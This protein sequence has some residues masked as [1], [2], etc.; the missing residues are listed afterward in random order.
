M[1]MLS[2]RLGSYIYVLAVI[3]LLAYGAA[4][5]VTV[6]DIV[7]RRLGMPIEG[8]VDLV[9]LF[10]MG[11]AWLVMPFAF[12]TSAHVGVDFVI[13]RF[14][15]G[16]RDACRIFGLVIAIVLLSL[17]LWYGYATA[18]QR[19]MFGDMSQELGIPIIWYWL[20]Q[21]LGMAA[22]IVAVVLV[23]FGIINKEAAQ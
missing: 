2:K 5:L 22:S 7:G 20:P 16:A 10:V 23:I 15:A 13:D 12:L 9:Q 17:M 4:A 1:G 14:P 6:A 18:S 21:L 19:I 8:V 11:G 3:G